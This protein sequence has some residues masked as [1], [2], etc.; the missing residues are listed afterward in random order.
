LLANNLRRLRQNVKYAG[1]IVLF[2]GDDSDDDSL[3]FDANDSPFPIFYKRNKPRL[4][5]GANLN[6]LIDEAKR[7]GF[8]IAMQSDDDH[9]LLR[10]LDLTPHVERLEKETA[11]IRLMGVGSHKLKAN[12]DETYWRVNWHSDELYITSNRAH[13]KSLKW[14]DIYGY[15]P[16]GLKLGGTEDGFCHLNIDYARS[17]IE[18][19]R[20]VPQVLIPLSHDDTAFSESGH[21]LQL[22]GY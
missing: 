22:Q 15:Y 4:G 21:S 7:Q 13:I 2:V 5:L 14:H 9:V 3:A 10:P 16:E 19:G 18:A 12:L 8:T 17:Q 6:Y 1:E 20:I 11:W